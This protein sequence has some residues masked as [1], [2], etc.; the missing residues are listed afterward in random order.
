M[1]ARKK[2]AAVIER[3]VLLARFL[4]DFLGGVA[5]GVLEEG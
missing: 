3:G 5:V 1:P 2:L 4:P